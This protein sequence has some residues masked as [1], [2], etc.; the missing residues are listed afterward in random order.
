MKIE[1]SDKEAAYVLSGLRLLADFAGERK[2][3]TEEILKLRARI[4]EE[5]KR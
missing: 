4:L 3:R 1:L 2:A 5:W